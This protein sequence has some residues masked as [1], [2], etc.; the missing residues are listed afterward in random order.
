MGTAFNY[1]FTPINNAGAVTFTVNSNSTGGTMPPGLSLSSAG[2]LSGTP[3]TPGN[4]E[5]AMNI[6]DGVDNVYQQYELYI[7]A[8]KI[9]NAGALPSSGILPNATQYSSYSTTLVASGGTGPYTFTAPNGL[10]GGF[11]LSSAGVISL[12]ST[13]G[14]GNYGFNVTVADSASNSYS[15]HMA[16]DVVGSPIAPMRITT[17]TWNDPVL[18]DRYGN[19]QSVCCGGTAPFTWTVTGLPPGLEAYRT[20]QQQLFQ[21]L[22]F[23]ARAGVQIFYGVAKDGWNLQRPVHGY[24]MRRERHPASWFRCTSACWI[25]KLP[26]GNGGNLPN[27][28]INVAYSATFRV[29]GGSG[30]YTSTKTVD[31][32]LP[33]GLT[34]TPST[35]TVSGTPLENGSN[36]NSPLFLFADSAGNTLTRFE[37]I[38]IS[39]GTSTITINSNGFEGYNLGT[40]PVGAFYSTQFSACCVA[41]YTWSVG[42]GSTLPAGLSLSGSGQLSGTPTTPGTYRFLI[43]A[44]SS[45]APSNAGVK[46]FV[47]TVTPISITTGSLPYGDVGVAYSASLAATGGN[48]VTLT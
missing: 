44:A 21:Q 18:G 12:T 30:P 11:A 3:T 38:S 39:G 17:L 7:Y 28:T 48:R 43:N 46:S 27:G 9:T 45:S 4:Y 19:V 25:C 32:E 23:H 34:V 29:L 31:G 47:L 41:S 33:D 8:L 14:P 40:T 10:P 5:I 6:S 13:V 2:V 35:L 24:S 16:L 22:R 20:K 1:Q 37:N 36:F 42:A 15:K 26:G